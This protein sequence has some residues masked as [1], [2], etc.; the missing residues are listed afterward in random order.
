[1]KKI[2]LIFVSISLIAA[3]N[4]YAEGEGKDSKNAVMTTTVEG[5]ILDNETGEGLVGVE[6][7]L[8]GTQKSTYTDFDGNFSFNSVLPGEYALKA[9]YVSYKEKN[10]NLEVDLKKKNS[11]QIK[12]ES[13]NQ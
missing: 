1:M 9:N 13:L 3:A 2:L 11:C 7:K 12:L 6:V 4:L 8:E 5:T 10:L